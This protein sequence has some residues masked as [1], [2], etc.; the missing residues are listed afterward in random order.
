MR[1]SDPPAPNV[2][3]T[4]GTPSPRSSSSSLWPRI[5]CASSSA[6][7]RIETWRRSVRS[8]SPSSASGPT[9][10]GADEPVAVEQHASPARDPLE[11]LC[12]EVVPQ[13]RR[14]VHPLDAAQSALRLVAFAPR[15]PDRLHAHL[16]A[17]VGVVVERE[18]RR[19][20]GSRERHREAQRCEASQVR[21]PLGLA[22]LRDHHRLL[23]QGVQCPC[24]VPRAHRRCARRARPRRHATEGR[25]RRAV[26]RP[27]SVRPSDRTK[28]R[29]KLGSEPPMAPWPGCV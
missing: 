18:G 8:K 19:L 27:A 13:E 29:A 5:A 22:A 14:D 6:S 4:S 20:A 10:P 1:T 23:L 7:L 12:R 25:S 3:T 26:A 9:S 24:R 16:A 28:A 15:L 11:R 21:A 17:P 2:T